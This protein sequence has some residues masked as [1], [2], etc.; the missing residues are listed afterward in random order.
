MTYLSFLIGS[1]MQNTHLVL[2]PTVLLNKEKIQKSLEAE[3]FE[4]PQRQLSVDE[5]FTIFAQHAS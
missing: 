1:N 2:R 5:M 3:R 4:L